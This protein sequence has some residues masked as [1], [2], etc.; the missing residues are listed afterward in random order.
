MPFSSQP[1]RGEGFLGPFFLPG[2]IKKIC[3][4]R[5]PRTPCRV[6]W[7]SKSPAQKSDQ[8]WSVIFFDFARFRS[9][10][11]GHPPRFPVQVS[12]GPLALAV[13]FCPLFDSTGGAGEPKLARLLITPGSVV[14]VSECLSRLANAFFRARCKVCFPQDKFICSAVFA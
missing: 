8:N 12:S 2:V 4:F 1:S 10:S 3:Q 5:V 14:S 7:A 11:A 13:G 9:G 6:K